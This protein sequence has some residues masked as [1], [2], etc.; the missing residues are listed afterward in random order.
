MV[1]TDRVVVVG[2]QIATLTIPALLVKPPLTI[3]KHFHQI[4]AKTKLDLLLRPR[5]SVNYLW[6]WLL[7][8]QVP[9]LTAHN[10]QAP[11]QLMLVV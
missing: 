7:A 2:V 9:S 10:H 6:L 8:S 5:A 3:C 11:L 1:S 4:L